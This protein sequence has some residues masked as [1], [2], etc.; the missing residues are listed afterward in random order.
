[1]RAKES[2]LGEILAEDA[3]VQADVADYQTIDFDCKIAQQSLDSL[4]QS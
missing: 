1:V 2:R 3:Y 4:K